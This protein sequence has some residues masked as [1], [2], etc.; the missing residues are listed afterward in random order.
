MLQFTPSEVGTFTGRVSIANSDRDEDPYTFDV[1]GEAVETPVGD[2]PPPGESDDV[3]CQ[4]GG[5]G[6]PA[7]ILL[8]LCGIFVCRRIRT[9]S[10]PA[11]R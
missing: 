3:G 11:W 9:T 2:L 8:H 5:S 4:L 10:R 1:N 7:L 6:N